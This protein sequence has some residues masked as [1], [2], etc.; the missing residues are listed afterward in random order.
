MTTKEAI[1]ILELLKNDLPK[2]S[3]TRVALEMAIKALKAGEQNNTFSTAEEQNRSCGDI[4]N[5][6]I[7]R[8]NIFTSRLQAIR[9]GEDD[10]T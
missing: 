4:I 9:E 2:S 7:D 5:N 6:A 10:L 8:Y 3:K 1:R